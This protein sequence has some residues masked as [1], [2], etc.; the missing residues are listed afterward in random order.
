MKSKPL[1]QYNKSRKFQEQGAGHYLKKKKKRYLT[2]GYW[3]NYETL[4]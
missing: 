3:L 1:E 4:I 2:K